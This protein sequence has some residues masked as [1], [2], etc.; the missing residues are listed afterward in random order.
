[1]MRTK[2]KK[3]EFEPV[4][5]WLHSTTHSSVHLLFSRLA[6]I[7]TTHPLTHPLCIAST[8][9]EEK[10]NALKGETASDE[11]NERRKNVKYLNE[12]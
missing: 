4:V 11:R 8:R 6:L 12:V 2:K 7:T 3:K 9:R 1:M 5:H 10:K